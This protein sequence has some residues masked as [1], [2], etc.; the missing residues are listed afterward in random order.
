MEI[1]VRV[2]SSRNIN[3]FPFLGSK[4]RQTCFHFVVSLTQFMINADNASPALPWELAVTVCLAA[5]KV[6]GWVFGALG[7]KQQWASTQTPEGSI[8]MN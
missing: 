1:W 6:H 7:T 4:R 2:Y 3:P 8:G 5:F